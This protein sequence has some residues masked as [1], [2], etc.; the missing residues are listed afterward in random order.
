MGERV[1]ERERERE[2][3]REGERVEKS[4]RETWRVREIQSP[5]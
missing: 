1:G 5:G 3:E 4:G 2:W